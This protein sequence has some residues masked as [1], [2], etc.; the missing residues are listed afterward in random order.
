MKKLSLIGGVCATAML[1]MASNSFTQSFQKTFFEPGSDMNHYSIEA[2]P[3]GDYVLAGT[4]F[5]PGGNQDIHVMRLDPNGN[6]IWSVELDETDDDRALD[7]VVDPYGDIVV[8]GYIQDPISPSDGD[9]YAVK[10]DG[11][12]NFMTDILVDGFHTAAGTNV[13][14]S[15]GTDT[16]IVGG[17]M[18]EPF[19]VPMIG[20]VSRIL[21]LDLNTLA[22]LNN[23]ELSTVH[24]KHD[25]INDIVETSTGYFV[26]GSMANT[27]TSPI[28]GQGVLA[29]FL[30]YTFNVIADLSFESTNWEHVGVS[31]IYDPSVDE[32]WLMSNNSVVHNPQITQIRD[33]SG[34]PFISTE[35]YLYVDPAAGLPDAAG[36]KLTMSPYNP[37][38]LVACGLFRNNVDYLGNM[39]SSTPWIVEFDRGSGSTIGAFMWPA[40]SPN[41]SAH[42]GGMFSTFSG[43]HPYFFNQEMMIPR[44]DGRGFT[45]VGPID[46]SGDFGID[47]FTSLNLRNPDVPCFEPID[48]DPYSISHNDNPVT[49]VPQSIVDLNP[50]YSYPGN[51]ISET[52]WCE[53]LYDYRSAGNNET[54]E[55]GTPSIIELDGTT[56]TVSPNPVTGSAFIEISGE[57][58]SGHQFV[59]RNAVGQEMYSSTQLE[60]NYFSDRIDLSELPSGIYF[61]TL[62]SDSNVTLQI[63]KLIKQ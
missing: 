26:T 32:V 53:S 12:G 22:V 20:C 18:G 39:N 55:D 8:V 38:S 5:R 63:T 37:G 25:N 4:L 47:V 56:M 62:S 59:L 35:Y 33:V 19:Q 16:Y 57:D 40:P 10:L 36:F 51:S 6:Q 9:L 50:N 3:N 34:A 7:L 28:G 48:C 60:G 14:H 30:D 24:M 41:F 23:K 11:A 54:D 1:L 45:I 42:G 44:P 61:L 43:E 21:E 27:L 15:V 49:D 58:L 29:V 52:V 31:A 2:A 17:Y 13:I 46:Q